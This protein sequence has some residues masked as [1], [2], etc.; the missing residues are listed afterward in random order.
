MNT[1]AVL[2]SAALLLACLPAFAEKEAVQVTPRGLEGYGFTLSTSK[3]ENGTVEFRITRDLAKA[4][5]QG[6]SAYL[7]VQGEVGPIVECELAADKRKNTL[8]YRFNIAPQ[9]V[10]SSRFTLW[11]VQ[12]DPTRPDE[13]KIIGGGT[14]YEFRLADFM[15]SS[16]RSQD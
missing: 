14:I 15:A 11:E 16:E 6:R 2:A 9:Q 12:A 5:W 3:R 10:R 13:E 4:R 8:H 1:R 7:T